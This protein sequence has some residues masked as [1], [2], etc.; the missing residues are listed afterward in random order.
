MKFTQFMKSIQSMKFIQSMKNMKRSKLMLWGALASFAAAFLLLNF[1]MEKP[2]PNPKPKQAGP[3]QEAIVLYTNDVHCKTDGYPVLAAYRQQMIDDG[4]D[5]AVVDA[6]DY[7][8]G[9]LLGSVTRG[10][11][12]IELKNAVPYD[13]SVPGNHE[14]DWGMARF[15]ELRKG[16][17]YAEVCLNLED[18]KTGRPVLDAYKI[19]ELAGRRVAFL[20]LCTPESY[21]KSTP[22]HFEDVEGNQAYGFGES[23]FYEKVQATVDAARTDGAE[24]VILVSHLGTNGVT[25]R[26][27][28]PAVISATRGIDAVIDG[29]SHEVVVGARYKNADGK[30]IP[31][32]QTGA[33]FMFFGKMTISKN[34]AIRTDL[35]TPSEMKPESE[36]AKKAFD[37]V[38][39]IVEKQEEKLA[40]LNEKLGVAEVP[41]VTHDPSNGLRLVRSAE[42][43]MG[44]FVADAYRAVLDAQ[45]GIVNGGGLRSSISVGDVTRYD[46]MNVSPW[47]NEM[48]VV[49][50]PGQKILD[51]LEFQ[52][53]NLPDGECGGFLHVSG[54]SYEVDTT[55]Q[56]PVKIDEKGFF[57]GFKEG[58]ARR[59]QN[60]HVG[61]DIMQPEN[62]YQVAGTVFVLLDGGDG[63]AAPEDVQVVKRGDL[64]SDAECLVKYFTE[65]LG[66]CVT[67]ENYPSPFGDGRIKILR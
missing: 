66:G 27:S 62:I 18:L 19:I 48:C 16:A 17:K 28:A 42:C 67:E 3:A 22:K 7:V 54:M 32:S 45:M 58:M 46:L 35:V 13:V 65:I 36:S 30:E 60:V 29:H 56:S 10:E 4:Y 64:P 59:V 6:G 61:D 57:A 33:R 44:D 2:E 24:L 63:M 50:L 40:Y 9:G 25:W 37:N 49:E 11:A 12:I 20:G 47:N 39:A 8:Q 51:M 14:F 5:V 1:G 55:I 38:Q 31:Y 23:T 41:L 43:S 21:T 15:L 52:S 26:W 53:R 34:G